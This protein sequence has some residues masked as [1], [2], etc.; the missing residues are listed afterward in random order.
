MQ[1]GDLVRNKRH[2]HAGEG[3]VTKIDSSGLFILAE[4]SED[5]K[6]IEYIVY[7]DEIEI[8]NASR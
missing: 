5:G 4:F 8:I 3:V 2:P 1:V 6:Q 7:T